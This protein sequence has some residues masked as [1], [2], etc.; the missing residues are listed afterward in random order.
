MSPVPFLACSAYVSYIMYFLLHP[1]SLSLVFAYVADSQQPIS[2][3]FPMPS[4]SPV[5]ANGTYAQQPRELLFLLAN[6]CH[7]A[8]RV[9]PRISDYSG[10]HV[11]ES[12]SRLVKSEHHLAIECA[13]MH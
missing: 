8:L 10:V 12:Q 7:F 6:I 4:L 1:L 3:P 13:C 11:C 9:R 5:V 2:F